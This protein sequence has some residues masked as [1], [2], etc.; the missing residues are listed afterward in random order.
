ML[1]IGFPFQEITDCRVQTRGT[2]GVEVRD[3][4]VQLA[5]GAAHIRGCPSL[6]EHGIVVVKVR[7]RHAEGLEDALVGELAQRLPAHALDDRTEQCEAGVAVEILG[8]RHEVERLLT[9]HHVEHV[10]LGDTVFVEAAA[11]EV[12][13]VP[14]VA[15]SARMREKMPDR[16]RVA[17]IPDF[18]EIFPNVVIERQLAVANEEHGG[19]RRELLRHTG[20]VENRARADGDAVL[21]VRHAVAL[22]VDDAAAARDAERTAG[23]I[24]PI[25][26]G[27][28][29]VDSRVCGVVRAL[30]CDGRLERQDR[31]RKR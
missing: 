21:E 16:D 8:A 4:H 18:R 13:E 25:P 3:A 15:Q 17:V 22:L 5:V 9:R 29:T 19:H 23:R 10:A 30:L 2:V 24:G 28:D 26:L 27:E 11:R 31:Q 6:H 14:L 20:D 12:Q 7:A 1:E